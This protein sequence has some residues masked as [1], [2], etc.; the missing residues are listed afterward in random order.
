VLLSTIQDYPLTINQIFQHGVSAYADSE[1][2]TAEEGESRRATFR[3]IAERAA[4]LAGALKRLGVE[5]GD[6]VG[7]FSWNIQ[8]HLEAYFA[9]PCMGAV[10]HTLNVRLFPEQLSYIINHGEDK[11]IIVDESLVPALANVASE[12]KTVEHYIVMGGGDGS[13][14]GVETLNYEELLAAESPEFPWPEID[15]RQAAG[16]C[17]TSGTTGNPKGVVYSHRCDFIHSLA[18]KAAISLT[19]HDRLLLVVPMFH[20]NAWGMPYTAWLSGADLILPNRFVQPEPLARLIERE[21]P[22]VAAA[23]PTVWN[24]LL[25]HGEGTKIDIS[26]LRMIVCGGAK[27]PLSLMQRFEEE[28]GVQIIQAW[29]MTETGPLAALAI[30]PK[31]STED[32]YWGWREKTGRIFGGVDVRIVDDSGKVMPRDGESV[33]EI[34]VRGSWITGSYYRDDAT[35]KF[36]DGWLRT[37][38]V[39][40]LDSKGFIHITDRAKDVIKSGGEWISSV[41][42]ESLLMAHPAVAEAAVIGVPDRRWDERPLACVVLKEG[43]SATPDELKEFLASRVAKWWLPERWAFIV[44]VPKT[45]VGKFDK[46]VLRADYADGKIKLAAGASDGAA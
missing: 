14:L 29:G 22:T 11:V 1:V 24:D 6:R 33:G 38:D 28:H 43:K 5:H 17:Y 9:V 31:G 19:D 21:R 40:S 37:G 10:I 4:R 15:E 8:E 34:E 32:E 46:K 39:G 42:L 26:S 13:A 27:V 30:P 45:S 25:R 23:V 36:H 16:M 41:E 35:E 3:Q 44:E 12:L 7:S 18:E 20:A 2:I